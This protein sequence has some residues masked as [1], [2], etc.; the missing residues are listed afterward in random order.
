MTGTGDRSAWTTDTSSPSRDVGQHTQAHGQVISLPSF[1][2]RFNPTNYL[3]WEIE[4]EIVFSH[5]H[6]SELKRVRAATRVFTSFASVWWSVH[7]KKNIDNQPTTWKDLKAVMRKHF[8]LLTI[9]VNCFINWN[10]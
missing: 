3:A 7:C 2:G 9:A 4:V 5:H 1:E 10:N 6:F 8:S